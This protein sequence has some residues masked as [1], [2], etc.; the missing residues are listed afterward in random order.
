MCAKGDQ[1]RIASDPEPASPGCAELHPV[2]DGEVVPARSGHLVLVG[3]KR[4]PAIARFRQGGVTGQ[5]AHHEENLRQFEFCTMESNGQACAWFPVPQLE[6]TDSP[7]ESRVVECLGVDR[8]VVI[9]FDLCCGLCRGRNG[10][11]HVTPLVLSRL[12]RHAEDIGIDPPP[13]KIVHSHGEYVACSGLEQRVCHARPLRRDRPVVRIDCHSGAP[14]PCRRLNGVFGQT[15]A[16]D[17]LSLQIVD[18]EAHRLF[19]CMVWKGLG[20]VLEGEHLRPGRAAKRAV[21]V[22][23]NQWDT[24][25]CVRILH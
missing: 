16:C 14:V 4:H 5:I 1:R 21:P 19:G 8:G 9:V 24:C 15:Q 18:P 20:R 6:F 22:I 23:E 3:C 7:L 11:E 13:R 25:A 2:I 10:L 17:G 12:A